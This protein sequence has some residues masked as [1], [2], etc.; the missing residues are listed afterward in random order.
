M[1]NKKPMNIVQTIVDCALTIVRLLLYY[2]KFILKTQIEVSQNSNHKQIIMHLFTHKLITHCHWKHKHN[3]DC[4]KTI[5][6]DA[7]QRSVSRR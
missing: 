5:A 6:S 2:E 7:S 3:R 4:A 1:F